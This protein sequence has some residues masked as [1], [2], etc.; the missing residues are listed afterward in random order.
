MDIPLGE[1]FKITVRQLFGSK[2]MSAALFLVGM[3]LFIIVGMLFPK[4]YVSSTTLKLQGEGVMQP[5][6]RERAEMAE[7]E[8]WLRDARQIVLSEDVLWKV[9]NKSEW[10]DVDLN[11]PIVISGLESM[12]RTNADI[13]ST[14]DAYIQF[15]YKD[16]DR[17]RAFEITHNLA[18]EFMNYLMA[19]KRKKSEDAFDFIGTQVDVY[20]SNLVASEERLKKFKKDNFDGTIEGAVTRIFR[21]EQQLETVTI[22]LDGRRFKLASLEKQATKESTL[23]K[24]SDQSAAIYRRIAQLNTE[25]DQMRL[26]YHDNYPDVIALQSRID[27]LKRSVG[28]SD[29][30]SDVTRGEQTKGNQRGLFSQLRVEIS[31]IKGEIAAMNVRK[32]KLQALLV[33][34]KEKSV[35]LRGAEAELAELT[36]DYNV[37]KNIYQDLLMR[38]ENARVTMNIE[39]E[40]KGA[41]F[42][43]VKPAKIAETTEGV[44]FWMFFLLAPLVGLV[45]PILAAFAV[46]SLDQKIRY[47]QAISE[48]VDAPIL[49][50]IPHY[51]NDSD[52]IGHK[53]DRSMVVLVILISAA[54][55]G[56]VAYLKFYETFLI[57]LK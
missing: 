34:Q 55:Y 26:I 30:F 36:R 1:L 46:V 4:Y 32:T 12:I 23:K 11:S 37:N 44:K 38:R 31:T 9:I 33:E 19:E 40:E 10:G 51:K 13:I 14:G 18:N 8:D 54:V 52:V 28:D 57:W 16:K 6:M 41:S 3:S 45:S 25:L 17:R 7:S 47:P 42:Q 53:R 15:V 48:F 43:V 20:K 2:K 27:E 49:L 29:E 21:L 22:D 39:L 35:R 56:L 50:T 5:L 24:G